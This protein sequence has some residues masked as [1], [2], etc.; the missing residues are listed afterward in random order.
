MQ[1]YSFLQIEGKQNRK[2]DFCL[3]LLFCFV[4]IQTFVFLVLLLLLPPLEFHVN[5]S[6]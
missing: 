5:R 4:E 2:D 1:G 3:G 6:S